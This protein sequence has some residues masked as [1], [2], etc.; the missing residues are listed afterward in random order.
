MSEWNIE[1]ILSGLCLV[2]DHA[3]DE[4]WPLPSTDQ[5]GRVEELLKRLF[6]IKEHPYWI[7][8]MPTGEVIVDA[9]N[10]DD[11]IIIHVKT[12][13]QCYLYLS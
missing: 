5:I 9:G 10:Y 11:R 6:A 4:G 2:F 12:R 8:P 7:Y 1:S 3:L 13:P